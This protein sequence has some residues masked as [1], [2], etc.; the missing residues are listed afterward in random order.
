M[1]LADFITASIEPIL[2]EWVAFARTLVPTAPDQNE[3]TLR[4][5]AAS[6]LI[7][8]A[9][10]MRLPEDD[11]ERRARS[12]G[13][14]RRGPEIE[15]TPARVHALNRARSG[16]ET[17]QMVS[18]FRA[19]RATVIRLWSS[20]GH[21]LTSD[22]LDDVSRFNEAVDAALAESLKYFLAEVDRARNLFLGVLGHDLRTPLATIM[23]CTQHQLCARPETAHESQIVLR[24]AAHMR[25][26]VDDLLDYTRS[27]LGVGAVVE[28]KPMHL[29]R[30]AR[31]TVEEI[32]A[33]H[34][35][36]PI[37][38]HVKG[39]A[40]GNWDAS[41]LHQVLSNLVVNALK[42]GAPHTPIEVAVDGTGEDVVVLTVHNF[43]AP[44]PTNIMLDLFDPLIRGAAPDDTD[45]A[46]DASLGLGLYIA[47]EIVSAHAGTIGVTSSKDDGTRFVV[48]LPRHL[49]PARL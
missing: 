27:R 33:I 47:R 36:R 9:R 21:H 35:G 14:L 48:R 40:Q 39:D 41:R 46:P 19:L 6:I 32:I 24:S 16:F 18:E 1:R 25:A 44:I 42:Y 20:S 11:R 3:L 28:P 43:G 31:E 45:A 8:I 29:D 17:N 38:L 23:S 26:L 5:D 4:D 30:F 22:D 49:A 2:V 37:E 10:D 7:E 13:L 12:R 34:P 15:A